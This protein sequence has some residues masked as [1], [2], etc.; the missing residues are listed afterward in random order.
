[1]T[2]ELAGAGLIKKRPLDCS[3]LDD[4]R[5]LCPCVGLREPPSFPVQE[6]PE[7]HLQKKELIEHDTEV[8]S[9][10]VETLF[11]PLDEVN[12]KEPSFPYSPRAQGIIDSLAQGSPQPGLQGSPEPFLRPVDAIRRNVLLRNLLQ[13][14]FRLISSHPHSRRNC[15]GE[16][17]ETMIEV[18]DSCLE[19]H[20][21][22]HLV[23]LHQKLVDHIHFQIEVC[24]AIYGMLKVG[25][26][27]PEIFKKLRSVRLPPNTFEGTCKHGT[28]IRRKIRNCE[29]PRCFQ[30]L[31]DR[32]DELL[33]E[34]P[35]ISHPRCP[36]FR[37]QV[38]EGRDDP[39]AYQT[40]E[41][42][43]SVLQGD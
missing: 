41:P 6:E 32:L 5:P 22:A 2:T 18:G 15:S 19:R 26:P 14:R 40:R 39:V 23:L 29:G 7:P 25:S 38:D 42:H 4:D 17:D 34:T 1:M 43:V 30:I 9:A 36:A 10:A 27:R 12:L 35:Q 11:Q 16:L 13:E 24:H 8:S 37:H 20:S 31:A 3:T 33:C 28:V 21:H